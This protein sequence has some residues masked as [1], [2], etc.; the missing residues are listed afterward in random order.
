MTD[1]RQGVS[2]EQYEV[3]KAVLGADAETFMRTKLGQYILGRIANEE[4]QCI[5][6]LIA[7]D[8]EDAAANRAIRNQIYLRRM[9]PKFIDEAIASGHAARKN[10]EQMESSQQDY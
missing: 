10:I 7:A 9:F 1:E 5:E 4:E 2:P 3:I 8:P 6:E